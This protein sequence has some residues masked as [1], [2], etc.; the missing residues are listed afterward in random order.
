MNVQYFPDH[1]NL[2]RSVAGYRVRRTPNGLVL[3]PSDSD[4][5]K[6]PQDGRQ[7]RAI[8]SKEPTKLAAND[9]ETSQTS[10]QASLAGSNRSG[11]ETGFG[12]FGTVALPDAF[13]RPIDALPPLRGYIVHVQIPALSEAGL[14]DRVMP[15]C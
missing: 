3:V 5:D 2:S 14:I 13:W 6:T 10:I 15:F 9:N 4:E 8:P 11:T 7:T 1:K 12:E